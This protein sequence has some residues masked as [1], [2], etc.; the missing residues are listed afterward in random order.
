[1]SMSLSRPLVLV[2]VENTGLRSQVC[3]ILQQAGYDTT[4]VTRGRQA[5]ARLRRQDVKLVL[6]G[7]SFPDGD[8][9]ELVGLMRALPAGPGLSIVGISECS[10]PACQRLLVEKDF[11]D[12]LFAPV[13]SERLLEIVRWY[14]PLEPNLNHR[15]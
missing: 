15:P 10:C 4:V 6:L 13:E 14:L 3:G 8:G 7:L 5:L 11:T 9:F 1:V 12:Y 2:A